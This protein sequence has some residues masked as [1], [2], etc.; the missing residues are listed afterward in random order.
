MNNS[1]K[2][3]ITGDPEFQL[4]KLTIPE[5]WKVI[6]NNFVDLE[7]DNNYPINQVFG[8]FDEDILIASYKDWFIDLGFYGG[9][10][11]NNRS[12]W[13]KIEIFR[14]DFDNAEYFEHFISRSTDQ[15]KDKLNL[16]FIAI[17]NGQLDN[18]RGIRYDENYDFNTHHIYSAIDNIDYKI[19]DKELED[20]AR[21]KEK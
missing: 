8:Y 18:V 5:Q 17:P 11:A 9:Y 2:R 12:G 20:I 13:F 14:G 16:Y 6:M 7:P 4:K 21:S 19:S 3:N 10:L 1:N 15:I